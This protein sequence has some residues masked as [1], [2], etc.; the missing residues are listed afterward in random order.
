MYP[1]HVGAP[2]ARNTRRG[3][4]ADSRSSECSL[5][6][7]TGEEAKQ[8]NAA[9]FGLCSR[10][11]RYL[12]MRDVPRSPQ[13]TAEQVVGSGRVVSSEEE[14]ASWRAQAGSE[15]GVPNTTLGSV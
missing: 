11:G 6:R 5:G 10:G 13:E 7:E 15:R 12:E 4:C 9:M 3:G 1:T 2:Q 14:R 8:K